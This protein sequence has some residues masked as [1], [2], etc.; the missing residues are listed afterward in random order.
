M[1]IILPRARVL[2]GQRAKAL[3]SKIDKGQGHCTTKSTK[4][5]ILNC[6]GVDRIRV[7]FVPVVLVVDT[8]AWSL[9]GFAS[10]AFENNLYSRDL[11][12][13]K[14]NDCCQ[15]SPQL[16]SNLFFLWSFACS[17]GRFFGC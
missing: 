1:G 4:R 3:D 17:F 2:R 10:V 14:N 11:L 5:D 15:L 16:S 12:N 8:C 6:A 9:F 7:N 13:I